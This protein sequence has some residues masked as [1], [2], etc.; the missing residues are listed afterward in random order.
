MHE[1]NRAREGRTSIVD[2]DGLSELLRLTVSSTVFCFFMSAP[3]GFKVP[4]RP[5]PAF[6]IMTTGGG[7]LEVEGLREPIRLSAGD[8]TILPRVDAISAAIIATSPLCHSGAGPSS[9]LR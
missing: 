4:A 2:P 8:L 9:D 6:H 1:H 7:W 3:W 5:M